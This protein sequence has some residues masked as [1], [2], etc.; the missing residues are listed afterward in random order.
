MRQ[1]NDEWSVASAVKVGHYHAFK[2]ANCQDA[3]DF[4]VADDIICGIGCDGCGEGNH[5]EVGARMICT[6]GLSEVSR[7]HQM[8][9]TAERILCDLFCSI[10]RF[11]EM[12][13]FHIAGPACYSN[14]QI[15]YYVKHH[16]LSTVIGFIIQENKDGIVFSCGDGIYGVDDDV[17]VIDQN[18][19]PKY[20]A[21]QA[22]KNP[23]SVGVNPENIPLQFVKHKFEANTV[24]RL[25]VASDGLDQP[26]EQKISL[27][28]LREPDLPFSL[29]G[30]QW[31]KK[32]QFGLKKWMNSRWDRGYF[33]DDCCIVTAERIHAKDDTSS[34]QEYKA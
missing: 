18:N 12:Q 33:D 11:I 6:F 25:F 34:G 19:T 4:F 9:F 28:R 31:G 2:G 22:L 7:L 1:N 14:E 13:I 10:V 3:A 24:N 16:W 26:D 23:E 8:G 30:Q 20:I 32:G 5:S 21:Y 17:I 27:A 15:A 29:H